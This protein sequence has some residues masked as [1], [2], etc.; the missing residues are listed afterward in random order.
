MTFVAVAV[1]LKCLPLGSENK[2]IPSR[3]VM[4][5]GLKY[6]YC[7]RKNNAGRHNKQIPK[8]AMVQS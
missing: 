5:F 7:V 1:V 3:T 8:C 2:L 6:E 4:H